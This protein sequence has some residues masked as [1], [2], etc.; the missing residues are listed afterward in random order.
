MAGFVKFSLESFRSRSRFL[1]HGFL[2][3]LTERPCE[4]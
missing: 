3:Y 2:K 1:A 4:I